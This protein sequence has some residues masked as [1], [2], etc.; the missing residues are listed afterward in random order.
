[1]SRKIVFNTFP[2]SLTKTVEEDYVL[3]DVTVWS[4]CEL[5]LVNALEH[6]PSPFFQRPAN[7][8]AGTILFKIKD[9]NSKV[10]TT[11][12]FDLE[13]ISS[14]R[15]PDEKACFTVSFSKQFKENC[16]LEVE[17]IV[18]IKMYPYG[19]GINSL[20]SK[21]VLEVHG[22]SWTSKKKLPRKFSRQVQIFLHNG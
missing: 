3:K 15:G 13:P 4:I 9:D 17:W 16:T 22:W 11:Y 18:K 19:N 10:Y 8:H 2:G 5:L 20:N 12:D 6:S 1:M 14:S 21:V 7:I